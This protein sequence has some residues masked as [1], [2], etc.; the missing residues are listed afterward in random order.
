MLSVLGILFLLAGYL[1][2]ALF[3]GAEGPLRKS[4]SSKTFRS[5]KS[6]RRSTMIVGAGFGLGL[7]LPI[8]L[9]AFGVSTYDIAPLEGLASLAT[10]ATGLAIRV[11]AARSLGRF[12]TRTLMVEPEHK[13][14]TSGPYGFVRHPGYLGS[15]LL[16]SGFGGLTSNFVLVVVFP[17]LFIAIYLYRI[18]AEERMLVG[19]LGQAYVQ[20][21]RRTKRLLPF[22][23]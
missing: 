10:M 7:V 20:Y 17:I 3:A 21:Q 19:G 8:A 15:I 23:Y 11:W 2:L 9:D 12:Y 16:W 4:A 13:V 5:G 1:L 18:G 14:V 22:I 6:D